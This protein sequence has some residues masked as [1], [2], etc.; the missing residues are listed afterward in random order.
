MHSML[1]SDLET[2]HSHA[3]AAEGF[4]RV[5]GMPGTTFQPEP[6]RSSDLMRATFTNNALHVM[7]TFMGTSSYTVRGSSSAAEPMWLQ[8]LRVRMG[9]STIPSK[10]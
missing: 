2:L 5:N 6:V 9:R 1:L 4:T 3:L 10:T 7:L 8:D